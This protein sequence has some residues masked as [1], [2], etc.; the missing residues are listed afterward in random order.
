MDVYAIGSLGIF[1]MGVF[2]LLVALNIRRWCI[3]GRATLV[4]VA[5]FL[6]VYAGFRVGIYA[7][8]ISRE[9]AGKWVGLSAT[10]F[11][12]AVMDLA[13]L[14]WMQYRQFRRLFQSGRDR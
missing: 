1:L 6:L 9:D 2:S 7:D 12:L 3:Y 14:H 5:L 4:Y 11:A 8:W 13:Y 10:G